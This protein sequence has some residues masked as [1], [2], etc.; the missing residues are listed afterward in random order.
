MTAKYTVQEVVEKMGVTAHTLRYYERI[1]LLP[2]IA[3][4]ESGHRRYSDDDLGWVRFLGLLRNTG[5]PIQKMQQYVCL[6]R[7]GDGT[8]ADRLPLLSKHQREVEAHIAC[9]QTYL[10]AIG[11][12]IAVYEDIIEN[13]ETDL[14][15]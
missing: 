12:K 8:M 11:R 3:R 2:P 15:C 5:M 6:E 14:V 13:G 9:L 1:G 10:G 4:A 7:E